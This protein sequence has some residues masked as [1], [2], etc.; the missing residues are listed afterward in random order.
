MFSVSYGMGENKLAVAICLLLAAYDTEVGETFY[1]ESFLIHTL[2]HFTDQIT[3]AL[4]GFSDF[5][6]LLWAGS[7]NIHGI[8]YTDY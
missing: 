5:Y 4:L 8:I 3:I 1:I 7:R 6:L 2:F